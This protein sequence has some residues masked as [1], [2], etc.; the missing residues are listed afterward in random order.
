MKEANIINWNYVD[1]NIVY[2]H[3]NCISGFTLLNCCPTFVRHDRSKLLNASYELRIHKLNDAICVTSTQIELADVL[4]GLTGLL[5]TLYRHISRS[6]LDVNEKN[7]LLS[8]GN[9]IIIQA[10][11]RFL[12]PHATC[13][14]V[15]Y[16]W[17]AYIYFK[18]CTVN[19][20]ILIFVIFYLLYII[21]RKSYQS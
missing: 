1:I 14:Y 4:R 17:N 19:Y 9:K 13:T 3:V 8:F 5:P 21:K 12:I 16:K 18:K 20:Y 15:V 10:Y 6:R 11:R 7:E 2:K